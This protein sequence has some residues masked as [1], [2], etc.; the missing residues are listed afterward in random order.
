MVLRCMAD[1]YYLPARFARDVSLYLTVYLEHHVFLK[2]AVP[3]VVF[4]L[5]SHDDIDPI[6]GSLL[7]REQR[8]QVWKFLN[9]QGHFL[10]PVKF[11][12]GFI[13]RDVCS[14]FAPPLMKHPA[15]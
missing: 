7:W 8:A 12:I 5:E 14:T 9:P 10:H 4:G 6:K 2:L 13:R 11:S 15:G 3:M 1:I